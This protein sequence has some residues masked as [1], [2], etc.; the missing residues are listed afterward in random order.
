MTK[1]SKTIL[2]VVIALLI[3]IVALILIFNTGKKEE[4]IKIGVMTI[5]SGDLAFLGNNI[6]QSAELALEDLDY[7]NV[8]LIVEDVGGLA[9]GK[10]AVSAYRKLVD[11]DKVHVIIDGMSSDATLAIA[12]LLDQDKIVM[13]TPLTG[14]ENI[15]NAAEYLFR[16]GPSDIKAGILP[17]EDLIRI[18]YAKVAMFTDNAEYTL[19]IAKYF[20]NSYEGEIVLDEII[21]PDKEDYRAELTKLN[22]RDYDAILILT[23]NG[24]SSAYLFKQLHELDNDKP[25][26]ANFIAFNGNAI[27]IAED[28][29]ENVYIYDPELDEDAEK[30]KEFFINYEI[31][32]GSKPVIPFHATGTY[33]AMKMSMEAINEVGYDGEKIH[34]YLLKNIQD[35]EGLNG[36]V[37]FDENGNTGTG[38]VL[39]QVR[40]KELVMV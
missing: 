32:Y 15:D 5:T 37:S 2:N 21:S 13:I 23:G 18:G 33:D 27:T 7:D 29:I 34:D 1:N 30:T 36:N 9:G 40:N 19:D 16:N 6:V 26:F 3:I 11:V 38:F 20:R 14:G 28:G 8:E 10:D 24:L 4:K 22:G 25:I 39:K 35:W 12:P 31:K 17:A